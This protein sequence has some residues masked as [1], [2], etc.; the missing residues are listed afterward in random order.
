MVYCDS[1]YRAWNLLSGE[2]GI[3]LIPDLRQQLHRDPFLLVWTSLNHSMYKWSHAWE[4][5]GW[6]YLSLHE[7]QRI[8][9]QDWV[10]I[11]DSMPSF[12]MDAITLAGI[13]CLWCWTVYFTV[14]HR[15]VWIT[16]SK[17]IVIKANTI[18][19]ARGLNTENGKYDAEY[20][21]T[22]NSAKW[23]QIAQNT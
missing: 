4:C 23:Y 19:I 16:I 7:L 11:N 22:G 21:S 2:T 5:M 15:G 14:T 3:K 8:T 12:I 17:K 20:S 9:A 18:K 10:W 13:W 1:F 6:D